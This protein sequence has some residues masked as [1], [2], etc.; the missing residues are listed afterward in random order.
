M[1]HY[2]RLLAFLLIGAGA[3]CW[4]GVRGQALLIAFRLRLVQL[5]LIVRSSQSADGSSGDLSQ[6]RW[7]PGAPY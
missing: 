3:T 4:L 2:T 1:T 7:S 6:H 5:F